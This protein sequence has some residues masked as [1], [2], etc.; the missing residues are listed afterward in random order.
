MTGNAGNN[1]LDGGGGADTLIGLGGNDIYYV[2][3][4]RVKVVEAPGGG[5]DTLYTSVGYTLADG[6][7]CRSCCRPTQHH[8]HHRHQS[9][10]QRLRSDVDRQCRQQHS[11]MAAA[12]PIP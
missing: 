10:R 12:A 1:V 7:Q 5:F 3:D 6:I 8:R 2:D 4:A 11:A 9:H